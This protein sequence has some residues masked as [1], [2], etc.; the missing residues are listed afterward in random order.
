MTRLLSLL[1]L[2][3]A[4]AVTGCTQ[5]ALVEPQKPVTLDGVYRLDPQVAWSRLASGPRELWTIDGPRLNQVRFYNGLADGARLR[6]VSGSGDSPLPQFR[7]TMSP[8]EIRDFIV[9]SFARDDQQNVVTSDLR[10]VGFGPDPGFRFEFS[11]A[12]PDGLFLIAYAA[13]EIHYYDRYKAVVERMLASL[14][15][16]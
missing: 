3:C 8:L 16:A 4:F 7:K 6:D 11:Y 9:A 13:P 1:A 15:A 12:T 14:R 10:P 2:A 5:F